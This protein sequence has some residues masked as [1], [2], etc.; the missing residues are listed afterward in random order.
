MKTEQEARVRR[1]KRNI[2]QAVLSTIGVAGIIAVAM[3]APN[4]FQA[5]PSLMGRQRYRLAYQARTAA[6]RLAAKGHV[7]FREKNG[8]KFLE[9]TDAGRRALAISQARAEAPAKRKRRWDKRY[10][11]VMFDIPQTRTRSR[12]RLRALMTEFG[13]LRLQD[14]VWVSPYDCEELITLI[15]AEL[16]FGREVIYVVAEAIEN[17]SW[18]KKHFQLT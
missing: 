16:H 9:I 15:K 10:R 7:R 2:Q 12:N 5:A 11:I 17:D 18:V 1:R 13:F 8:K 4:I 14:S 6:S 3:I